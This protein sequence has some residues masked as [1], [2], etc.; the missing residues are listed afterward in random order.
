MS[1]D[2]NHIGY[3][4]KQ[5]FGKFKNHMLSQWSKAIKQVMKALKIYTSPKTQNTPK[6]PENG[7]YPKLTFGWLSSD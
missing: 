5:L 6:T 3:R 2:M 4:N 7:F 1:K